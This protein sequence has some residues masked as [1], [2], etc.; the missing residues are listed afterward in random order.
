M[1]K[2]IPFLKKH[3]VIIE[4]FVLAILITWPLFKSGYVFAVDL[5]WPEQMPW[6]GEVNNKYLVDIFLYYL[7]FIIPSQLIEK[8]IIFITVFLAGLSAHKLY[9]S[10]SVWPKYFAGLLYLFTPFFFTRMMY[11]HIFHLLAYALLPFL[12]KSIFNFLKKQTWK[13]TGL[14]I[15]YLFLITNFSL[16]FGFIAILFFLICLAT[17]LIYN[18]ITKIKIKKLVFRS[19]IIFV[20]LFA[21]FSYWLIPFAQGDINNSSRLLSFTNLDRE[22]FVTNSGGAGGGVFFNIAS[23]YGFWA[24]ESNLYALPKAVNPFWWV[25]SILILAIV[26]SGIIYGLKNKKKR[27]RT[28]ILTFT[29]TVSLILSIGI[30]FTPFIPLIDLLEKYVPFYKGMREPQKFV[31]LLVLCYTYLGAQGLSIVYTKYLRKKFEWLMI[32]PIILVILYNPLML[33]GFNGQLFSSQYPNDWHEA[34]I[35]LNQDQGDFQILILPWHQ[36]MS[37]SFIKNKVA[38]PIP[39]KYFDKPTICGDNMEVGEIYSSS[40]RPFSIA[41]ENLKQNK[42]EIKTLGQELKKWN[43]KYIIILKEVDWQDYDFINQQTDLN[44]IKEWEKLKIYQN[45]NY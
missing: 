41:F 44:L 10:K 24:D 25:I 39:C 14:I 11:G 22:A 45:T 12:A 17:T 26:I 31:G 3:A 7:N 43:I 6:P 9:P 2:F 13:N 21:C 27:L 15:L 4:Y 35:Y 18:L 23:M 1:K 32:I 5:V 38:A 30:A 33:N 34:N 42:N 20:C 19:I 28:I 29:A 40:Q 16:H 37:Y 36:Y 8:L